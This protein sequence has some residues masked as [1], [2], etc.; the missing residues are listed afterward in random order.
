MLRL[1]SRSN[2]GGIPKVNTV[3]QL[4]ETII[5]DMSFKD[6]TQNKGNRKELPK[7]KKY[8]S[9]FSKIETKQ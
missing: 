8:F 7:L 1:V 9:S 6:Y 2:Q 5:I 3:P 4:V